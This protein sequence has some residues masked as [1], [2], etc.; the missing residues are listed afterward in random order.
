MQYFLIPLEIR[1]LHIEPT[2][3][4]IS[5][6]QGFEFPPSQKN[7]KINKKIYKKEKKKTTYTRIDK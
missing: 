1:K 4:L 2:P 7:K 3:P 5:Q 6:L